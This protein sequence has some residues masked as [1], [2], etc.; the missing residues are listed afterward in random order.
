MGAAAESSRDEREALLA[1]FTSLLRPL[2][3]VALER[4]ITAREGGDT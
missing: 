4:G 3:P 2:M 1:L